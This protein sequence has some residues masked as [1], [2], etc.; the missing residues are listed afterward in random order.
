MNEVKQ[1]FGEIIS[2][3]RSLLKGMSVTGYYFLHPKEIIT[4]Q[5]PENRDTL[6]IPEIFR[7]ELI[8]TH[9]ENN[10]HKCTGCSACQLACPNGSITIISDKIETESGKKKKIIDK[11]IYNL[12]MCTFCNLCVRACPTD[13]IIMSNGFEHAVYDRMSLIK[14]LN[15]PGSKVMEGVEE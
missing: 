15:K 8:M 11:H 5:Y 3:V 9:N 14:T 12:A 4:Q 1:Y 10:E 6:N 7:G 13:A 2:G